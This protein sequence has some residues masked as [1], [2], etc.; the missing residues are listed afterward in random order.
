MLQMS[1]TLFLATLALAV[2]SLVGAQSWEWATKPVGLAGTDFAHNSVTGVAIDG[3]GAVFVVGQ[4]NDSAD[5]GGT[6]LKSENVL[7]SYIAKLGS[8]GVFEWVRP[9]SGPHDADQAV[10]VAVDPSGNAYMACFFYDSVS[11][12][13]TV[14]RQADSSTVALAK[15]DGNGVLQWARLAA[16]LTSSAFGG[17]AYSPTG[18]VYLGCGNTLAK[19]TLDG[20]LEWTRQAPRTPFLVVTHDVAVDVDGDF[21]YRTGQFSGS[22]DLGGE[23][24][25]A[26]GVSNIDIFLAKYD[27]DGNLIWARKAG[28]PGGIWP[29][30]GNGVTVD[31][32]GNV[33]ACGYFSGT[34]YFGTDSVSAGSSTW[35]MFIAKYSLSG[36]VDWVLGG[37]GAVNT[38]STAS[39]VRLV[40]NE[41]ELLVSAN[42]ASAVTI[43][44]STF[45]I[46]AGGDALLLKISTDGVV[47]G[48][49]QSGSTSA[50]ITV[51]GMEVNRNTSFAVLIGKHT[52]LTATFSPFVLPT[53]PVGS[54]DGF[55]VGTIT[56][57][58][59]PVEERPS[60]AMPSSVALF[61]NYPNPF[62]PNTVIAF[63][64]P[65][66][67][68][69]ALT[70]YNILG[71]SIRVLLDE[72]LTAGP[73]QVEWDGRDDQGRLAATGV[74]VYRIQ[75]AHGDFSRKMLLLK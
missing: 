19:Y 29:E 49:K 8:G 2:P 51:N 59:T 43:G 46:V 26:G 75:T 57:T 33:Y 42:F 6:V 4:F 25:D 24:L 66:R 50:I 56:D 39:D 47:L 73:Y 45:S 3:D 38:L 74:Y 55:I 15:F 63:D 17:I 13:G 5:F 68:H 28:S 10:D 44:D 40:S 7:D 41:S 52:S 27:R 60:V 32:D 20:D 12:D 62:N 9:V 14:V 48:G 36:E 69:A 71:R 31:R 58:P 30:S 37:S 61:Q 65:V 67:T 23:I 70:I 35:S 72:E 54:A 22:L 34:A 16:G 1:W 21:V 53:P 11:F 18:H 64:L